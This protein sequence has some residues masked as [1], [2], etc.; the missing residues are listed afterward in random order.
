MAKSNFMNTLERSARTIHAAAKHPHILIAITILVSLIVVLFSPLLITLPRSAFL[1]ALTEQL[2]LLEINPY[3][4]SLGTSTLTVHPT[5]SAAAQA[6]ADDMIE[7]DYF[8]HLGPGGELPWTWIKDAGYTY[9][10]AGENL[11][12]D[13]SDPGALVTAWINSPSHRKNIENGLFSDIGIG[14]ASGDF[15]GRTTNVIVMFVGREYIPT[16]AAVTNPTPTPEPTLAP[17]PVPTP[18][19]TPMPEP[20][21]TPT[22]EPT[23][24]PEPT[25]VPTPTPEPT[26]MPDPVVPEPE[27]AF[28]VITPAAAE[29]ILTPARAAATPTNQQRFAEYLL[30]TALA[31]RAILTAFLLAALAAWAILMLMPKT[32]PYLRHF[33]S[34]LHIALLAFLWLPSLIR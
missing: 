12:I 24:M 15:D 27:E 14:I 23:P 3:R 29:A 32:H 33:P 5:L 7:R 13:F 19:P 9:S 16:V 21:P 17:E 1:S 18:E 2:V 10:G 20:T 31:L 25:P 6:K 22:P 26:P 11:A 8:S 30:G 28:V 34:T 4:A